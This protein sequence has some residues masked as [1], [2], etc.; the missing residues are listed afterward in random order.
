[1][2]VSHNVA[3]LIFG[4]NKRPNVIYCFPEKEIFET[5]PSRRKMDVATKQYQIEEKQSTIL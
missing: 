4:H 5:I 1:M 2:I 3:P